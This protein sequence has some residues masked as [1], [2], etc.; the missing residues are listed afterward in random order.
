M[1]AWQLAR[2]DVLSDGRVVGAARIF[3]S[4]HEWLRVAVTF[5]DGSKQTFDYSDNVP[6]QEG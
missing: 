4:A 5:A 1:D 2:G 3:E 6:L